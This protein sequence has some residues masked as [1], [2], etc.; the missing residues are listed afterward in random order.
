MHMLEQS[1]INAFACTQCAASAPLIG[2]LSRRLLSNTR[3]LR[4]RANV[5]SN[6]FMLVN[7][8]EIRQIQ[9]GASLLIDIT[10][11]HCTISSFYP[12]SIIQSVFKSPID[13]WQRQTDVKTRKLFRFAMINFSHNLKCKKNEDRCIKRAWR[14]PMIGRLIIEDLYEVFW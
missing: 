11:F 10:L 13:L 3:L 6:R 5:W 7:H 8:C 14:T 9:L 4:T 12:L 1:R 2:N